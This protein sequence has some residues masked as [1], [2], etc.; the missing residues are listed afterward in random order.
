MRHINTINQ[1]RRF[2]VRE[3]LGFHCQSQRLVH[4]PSTPGMD[5]G[6]ANANSLYCAKK[7]HEAGMIRLGPSLRR[8]S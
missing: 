3:R 8:Q 4:W 7:A 5:T 2:V 6:I 1:W